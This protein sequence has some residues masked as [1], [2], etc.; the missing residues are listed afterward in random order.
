MAIEE[1]TPSQRVAISRSVWAIAR[2]TA[3]WR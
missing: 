2:G 1:T 3:G